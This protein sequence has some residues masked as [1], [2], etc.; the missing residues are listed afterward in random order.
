[1]QSKMRLLKPQENI[2]GARFACVLESSSPLTRTSRQCRHPKL[3]WRQQNSEP[4][5]TMVGF[6]FIFIN[7]TKTKTAPDRV[8]FLFYPSRVAW[9]GIM[10][11]RA[12]HHRRRIFAA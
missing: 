12:W 2:L 10:R 1:L 5:H 3:G 11:Q 9:Y 8:P 4:Y 6:G 7:C